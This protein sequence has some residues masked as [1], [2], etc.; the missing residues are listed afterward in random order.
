VYGFDPNLA[1][2]RDAEIVQGRLRGTVSVKNDMKSS[3]LSRG[4]ASFVNKQMENQG[5]TG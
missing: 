1:L 2:D 3:N 4:D 5:V